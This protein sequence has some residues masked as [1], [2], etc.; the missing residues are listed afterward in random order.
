MVKGRVFSG[1]GTVSAEGIQFAGYTFKSLKAGFGLEY[2]NNAVTLKHPEIASERLSLSADAVEIKMNEA[3]SGF[4][5]AGRGLSGHIRKGRPSSGV[6][7]SQ[8]PSI[9]GLRDFTGD[10][11]I[12]VAEADL[13]GTRAGNITGSGKFDGK[14]FSIEVPR[15]DVGG[16]MISLRARGTVPAGPFPIEATASARNIALDSLCCRTRERPRLRIQ[17]IR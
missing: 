6:V 1:D 13:Q 15:A 8:G 9:P 17:G 14:V 4:S 12:N 10:F 11:K 5:I 16:G 7:I 3:H 2:K